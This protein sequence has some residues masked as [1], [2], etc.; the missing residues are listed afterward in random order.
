MRVQVPTS[1]A[2]KVPCLVDGD[3]AVWDSLAI[4]EYLAERHPGVWPSRP[5]AR[6]WARSAAAEMHSGFAELRNRCSM[7]CGLRVVL[8]EVPPAQESVGGWFLAIALSLF[9]TMILAAIFLIVL[10]LLRVVR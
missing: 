9:C 8:N 10:T 3:I 4:I 7:T 1:A 6:A 5:A 2:G